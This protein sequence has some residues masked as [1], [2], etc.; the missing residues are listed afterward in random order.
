[1][2][3]GIVVAVLAGSTTLAHAEP[4]PGSTGEPQF[5][6]GVS[7]TIWFPQAD[8]DDFSDESLGIR[9]NFAFWIRP[10]VAVVATFDYVFVNEKDRVGDTTY[11]AISVGGRLTTP[12]PSQVKPYGE[13]LIGRHKLEGGGADDANLGFRIGGGASL[14]L[15]SNIVATAGL[16]FSSVSF[17]AGFFDVDVD[18]I[19][20]DLGIS[21][22]F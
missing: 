7:L 5:Q 15:R 18:A 20:V 13:F 8:A 19:V 9:P 1:M 11:Y 4:A 17:D 22:R 12:R 21:G 10:F 16:A 3:N 14:A 2:R 6:P